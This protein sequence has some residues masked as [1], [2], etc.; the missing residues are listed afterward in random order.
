MGSRQYESFY[1][2]LDKI[3]RNWYCFLFHHWAYH[4]NPML[5]QPETAGLLYL[6]PSKENKK[7][8]LPINQMI[9]STILIIAFSFILYSFSDFASF[10]FF[11]LVLES[12]TKI[13]RNI[14]EYCWSLSL[15]WI[16]CWYK[17]IFGH[18][19]FLF[20]R[21]FLWISFKGKICK[22]KK[23]QLNGLSVLGPQPHVH[24]VDLCMIH[25][26]HASTT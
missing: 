22:K 1:H 5:S 26:C 9:P 7:T 19:F 24:H 16:W 12:W 3:C 2:V 10:S 11:L 25:W 4:V 23:K 6:A 13:V 15:V 8:T 17:I 14:M 21:F 18:F 20:F